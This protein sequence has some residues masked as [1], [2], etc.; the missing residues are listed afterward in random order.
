MK[1]I[2]ALLLVTALAV[3]VFQAC[4]LGLC[5]HHCWERVRVSRSLGAKHQVSNWPCSLGLS[6]CPSRIR[7]RLNS[8]DPSEGP[9]L[10]PV[11]TERQP[12]DLPYPLLHFWEYLALGGRVWLLCTHW[13]T[14]CSLG[15]GLLAHSLWRRVKRRLRQGTGRRA[16]ASFWTDRRGKDALDD[17]ALLGR[18]EANAAIMVRCLK[19][20]YQLRLQQLG[21]PHRRKKA[22][23]KHGK[24]TALVCPLRKFI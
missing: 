23:N 17:G 19:H 5:G 11:G 10:R 3:A 21:L 8:V 13:D 24:R 20:L 9:K 18:T 2:L 1:F 4:G 22:Q 14:I 15:M 6:S 7:L 16:S 12:S